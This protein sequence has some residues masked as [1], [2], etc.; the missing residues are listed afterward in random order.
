MPPGGIRARFAT[1]APSSLLTA[2]A[3]A[4]RPV[5]LLPPW[6]HSTS[7]IRTIRNS[8][9]TLRRSTRARPEP[10]S[11]Y[12]RAW[13]TAWRG[14]LPGGTWQGG[15]PGRA[16]RTAWRGGLPGGLPE[17][18]ARSQFWGGY[19]AGVKIL[20]LL[21]QAVPAPKKVAW[22]SGLGGGFAGWLSRMP[23]T[24]RVFRRRFPLYAAAES[25]RSQARL[26]RL[27]AK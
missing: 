2:S 3:L 23:C 8:C 9:A 22:R 26:A 14:G 15:L 7:P 6:R 21:P 4:P 13:R 24:L 25:L 10:S 1:R 11:S 17:Q 27:L 19:R 20:T 5:R 12:L 16:W 18:P